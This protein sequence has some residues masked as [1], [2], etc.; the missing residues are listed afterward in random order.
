[1]IEWELAFLFWTLFPQRNL[2]GAELKNE[3]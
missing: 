2:L 1:V 3:L